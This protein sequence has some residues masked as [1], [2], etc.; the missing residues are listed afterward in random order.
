MD[1]RYGLGGYALHAAIW[2][3]GGYDRT[4]EFEYWRSYA[5]RFGRNVLIPFCALGEAGAY[6]ARHGMTV[7]AFDIVPQMIEEGKRRFG[8]VEG[9]SLHVCDVTD[10]AIDM[11][12]AD[13]CF[14]VDFGHLHRMEDVTR[15]I[16]CIGRHM[17]P[18]GCLVIE[19][20]LPPRESSYSPPRTF[21]HKEQVYPGLEVWKVGESREDAETG[22]W[23][24]SQTVYVRHA[25]GH[26]EQFGHE[27]Y[28]QSYARE[29]WLDALRSGGFEVRAEYRDRAHAPWNGEGMIVFEAIKA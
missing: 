3:W 25:D 24:C 10:F 17:R 22:R 13:F 1:E 12:P 4:E 5:S 23:H 9:L 11:P 29:A 20:G 7:H 14:A 6:M 19:A 16:A 15:A 28:L 27:F 8:D 21:Y 18:G 26:V 2:D